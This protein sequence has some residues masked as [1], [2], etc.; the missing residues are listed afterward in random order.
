MTLAFGDY[1]ESEEMIDG[2]PMIGAVYFH[3]TAVGTNQPDKLALR[4]GSDFS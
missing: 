3:R 1:V 4:I 2:R